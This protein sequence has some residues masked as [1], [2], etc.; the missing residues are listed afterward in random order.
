[1]R[2]GGREWAVRCFLRQD[3]PDRELV[4][5]DDSPDAADALL[6][7]LPED[8]GRVV[9]LHRPGR[10]SAGEKRNLAV[11][12]SRGEVV[13]HWD[14][15]DWSAPDRLTHQ[16]EPAATLRRI[17]ALLRPGGRIVAQDILE[18]PRYPS[19]DP[20]VPAVERILALQYEHKRR[21]GVFPDVARHYRTLC[22]EAGLGL[23][24]QRGLF[25]V[26]P[27]P[28]GPPSSMRALLSST[29][30]GL[31]EYGLAT[32]DEIEAVCRGLQ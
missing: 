16:V 22:G 2:C 11:E 10:R 20:P 25:T 1:M 29:R 15:D 32:D 5:V 31:V 26:P 24:S 27:D 18:D 4:I 6:P 17:A 23:V 14:D 13:V 30:R 19:F 7:D 8:A 28:R 3:Y 21:R 12:R 9:Y